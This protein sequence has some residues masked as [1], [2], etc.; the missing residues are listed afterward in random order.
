MKWDEAKQYFNVS[1][2]T[3]NGFAGADGGYIA[4]Y[5]LMNECVDKGY[6]GIEFGSIEN[7]KGSGQT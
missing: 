3:I 7:I 1:G 4:Q 5:N 2:N 6:T